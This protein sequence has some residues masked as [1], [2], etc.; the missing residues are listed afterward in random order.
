[1]RIPVERSGDSAIVR[2]GGDLVIGTARDLYGCLRALARRREVRSVVVDL[3]RTG[4]LDSAGVAC[5]SLCLRM[6][7]DRG[8]ELELRDPSDHHRAA[9]D[10]LPAS[11]A[12]GE[13]TPAPPGR[14]ERIGDSLYGLVDKAAGVADLLVDTVRAAVT[15]VARRRKLPAG[16]VLEHAATMG[17]DALPII[18]LLS[19]LLGVTLAFQASVQL[20]RFGADVFVA[21]LVGVAVVREFGPLMT[22]II[23]TGRSGAAIA[24]EI[25]SMRVREEVDALR[26]MGVSPVRFLVV[27]RLT[28]LTAVGPALTLMAMFI[29]LAGGMLIAATVMDLAPATFLARVAQRVTLGDVGHGLLKSLVFAWIVG[30]TGVYMGLRAG[31]GASS[32]GLAATRAVV[33]SLFLI[34]VVD[35]VFATVATLTRAR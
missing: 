20:E 14:L 9:L 7:Q 1:M 15:V 25:G 10:L 5:I 3:S 34:I 35:S 19:F 21:D 6:M 12:P 27:P 26:V 22:A 4:R 30:F 8:K 33:A 2:P 23:L 11:E 28:A 16:S 18:G 17:V 29:G 13:D 24:A 32:V 31:G